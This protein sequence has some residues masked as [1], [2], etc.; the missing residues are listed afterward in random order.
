MSMLKDWSNYFNTTQDQGPNPLLVQAASL[1]LPNGKVLDLGAGALRDTKYLLSQGFSVT[2]VDES[3]LVKNFAKKINNNNFSY[4][5]SSIENFDFSLTKY[6]LV[7]AQ[8]TLPFL[9]RADL[10]SSIKNIISC[11]KN[12]GVFTGQFFGPKDQ[13]NTGDN[14]MTFLT[15][16]EVKLLLNGFKIV[17]FKEEEKDSSAADGTPKH[18]H[19]VY[20]IA[21]KLA[22]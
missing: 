18:W 10:E 20:F 15:G 13:W 17:F 2:A 16:E 5:I 8:W 4:Q 21:K 11:L 7:S 6:D 9:K 22:A 14:T 1:A 19:V 12:D 3:E